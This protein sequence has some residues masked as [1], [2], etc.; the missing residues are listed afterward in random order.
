M[1]MDLSSKIGMCNSIDGKVRVTA[2]SGATFDVALVRWQ[3]TPEVAI[4]RPV[5]FTVDFDGFTPD[6]LRLPTNKLREA[7]RAIG[8]SP[9]PDDKA[10]KKALQR[11]VELPAKTSKAA[12]KRALQALK[13]ASDEENALPALDAAVATN[14][15]AEVPRVA[16]L[17]DSDTR[18]R[19]AKAA[20]LAGAAE[21]LTA[22]L[23]GTDVDSTRL[24]ALAAAL[25][26]L[27]VV[28][29]LLAA[30][31]DPAGIEVDAPASDLEYVYSATHSILH[32]AVAN[33]HRLV[34]A[35]LLEAGAPLVDPA[36]L[37]NA[38][39]L[40][41]DAALF[42]DLLTAGLDPNT[43]D[44]Q[45]HPIVRS[46]G[47]QMRNAMVADAIARGADVNATYPDGSTLLLHS[48]DLARSED[49]STF[50]VETLLDSGADPNAGRL[51]GRSPLALA[52]EVPHPPGASRG[53]NS[54]ARWLE[55]AGA[56]ATTDGDP[57]PLPDGDGPPAPPPAWRARIDQTLTRS[58]SYEVSGV[59]LTV[60]AQ[61]PS[62]SMRSTSIPTPQWDGLA[63]DTIALVRG[64]LEH[65]AGRPLGRGDDYKTT[66]E[67]AFEATVEDHS[68]TLTIADRKA[69]SVEIGVSAEAPDEAADTAVNALWELLTLAPLAA[70]SDR[71]RFDEHAGCR[72]RS[73]GTTAFADFPT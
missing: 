16:A 36:G 19:L 25:G 51:H 49:P 73:D 27:F 71:F 31:A 70:Y 41:A 1:A 3:F 46:L 10:L 5:G 42:G 21:T 17:V 43:R 35:E 6:T 72:Y 60:L 55:K 11:P 32:W 23:P 29:T 62:G 39:I 44:G 7:A 50:F 61:A 65:V 2:K 37:V 52:L 34:V 69:R 24:L 67:Y 30:G 12:A 13:A 56:V 68:V 57:G 18:A 53:E 38:V 63:T 20:V 15:A 14:T 66:F 45:G 58:P 8:D 40:S 33:G 48:I 64:K 59:R 47:S 9:V 26:K 4:V 54:L 28:R 22:L